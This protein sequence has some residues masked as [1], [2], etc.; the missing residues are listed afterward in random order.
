MRAELLPGILAMR[1][2]ASFWVNLA[3][4]HFEAGQKFNVAPLASDAALADA[5]FFL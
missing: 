2:K 4:S 5:F 3:F 1:T